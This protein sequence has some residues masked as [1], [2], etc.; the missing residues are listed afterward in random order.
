MADRDEVVGWAKIPAREP[1][2]GIN[3]QDFVSMSGGSGG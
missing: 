1:G 3:G 2:A